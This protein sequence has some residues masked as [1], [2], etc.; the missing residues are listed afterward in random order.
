MIN[1]IEINNEDYDD[2]YN[3]E[4]NPADV[5]DK[6]VIIWLNNVYKEAQ[7]DRKATSLTKHIKETAKKNKKIMVPI[8]PWTDGGHFTGACQ[9]STHLCSK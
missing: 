5:Y 8:F 1:S 9:E 4:M 6:K 7:T 3:N 2:K